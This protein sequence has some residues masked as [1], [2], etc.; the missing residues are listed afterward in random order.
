MSAY[1]ATLLPW[2]RDE[3]RFEL[4]PAS[5][6]VL[7]PLVAQALEHGNLLLSSAGILV[8]NLL[9]VVVIYLTEQFL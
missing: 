3:L 2:W 5:N 1:Q 6:S 9:V 7:H 4:N 8:L